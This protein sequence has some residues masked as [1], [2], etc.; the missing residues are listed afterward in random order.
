MIKTLCAIPPIRVSK[1]WLAASP[2]GLPLTVGFGESFWFCFGQGAFPGLL[3]PY[4]EAGFHLMHQE[5][6]TPR[7]APLMWREG[8][9]RRYGLVRMEASPSSERG[10]GS[11][12]SAVGSVG[13]VTQLE[14]SHCWKRGST[15]CKFLL[16]IPLISDPA[17]F[18]G[19]I[20]IHP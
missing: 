9:G 7:E 13:P 20:V 1:A 5:E 11:Q 18:L 16:L 10:W 3:A 8:V 6:G 4:V 14:S 15:Y 12:G 19:L 2:S 17:S